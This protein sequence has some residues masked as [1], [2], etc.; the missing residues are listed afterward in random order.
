M[1][2][3]NTGGHD[4]GKKGK[5]KKQNLRVDFT[6][7]VDMNM[8]LITFF[9]FCTTLSKPQM[10]NLVVPAKDKDMEEKDQTKVR[11]DLTVTVILGESNKCFYYFGKLTEDKYADYTFLQETDYGKDGLR[12]MIVDRNRKSALAMQELRSQKAKKEIK[13]E[14]FEKK[15]K[16]IRDDKLGL[17]VVIK[18]TDGSTFANLVSVLDEMQIC[19]VGKY[20]IV[21]LTEG[22]KFL[23]QNYM[24]KGA[25]SRQAGIAE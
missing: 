13:E 25:L 15:S 10:M 16:E 20:A 11:D 2:E 3:V 1:A 8:L 12:K 9:M 21:D 23:V 14:E 6:P 19:A 17:V 4:E 18:P 7:M 22:D 5:P 24:E